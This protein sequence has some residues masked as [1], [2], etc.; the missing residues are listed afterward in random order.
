MDTDFEYE[1]D[2]DPHKGT[3]HEIDW[4]RRWYREIDPNTGSPRRGWT[5]ATTEVGK[6]SKAKKQAQGRVV[7]KRVRLRSASHVLTLRSNTG[8]VVGRGRWNGY[9]IVRL[10]EPATYDNGVGRPYELREIVQDI[11]NMDV[12]SE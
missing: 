9:F 1:A 10:D 2:P 12:L 5:M 7:G 11:D 6:E 8:R 4:R 3:W